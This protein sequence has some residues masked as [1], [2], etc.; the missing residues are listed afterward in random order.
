MQVLRL[1]PPNAK[2]TGRENALAGT[3]L[4]LDN[5]NMHSPI[6]AIVILIGIRFRFS[7]E[8]EPT[9]GIDIDTCDK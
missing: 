7:R 3:P 5:S 8:K 2:L 1:S 9:V 6:A 4:D